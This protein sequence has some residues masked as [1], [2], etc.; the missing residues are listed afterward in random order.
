MYL[1][2]SVLH[3]WSDDLCIKILSH[4]RD[5]AGPDTQLL[6]SER[7]VSYACVEKDVFE[8][9][10]EANSRETKIPPKP[11]LPNGGHAVFPAYMADLQ[12]CS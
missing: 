10:A 12:V 1:L 5:A 4:I 2:K 9:V 3:D 11:L 7:V 6:I 8:K